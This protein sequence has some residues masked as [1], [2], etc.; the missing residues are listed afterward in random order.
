V[1]NIVTDKL[2]QMMEY[3]IERRGPFMDVKELIEKIRR[4]EIREAL[5]NRI[6]PEVNREDV[7]D[8]E[9]FLIATVNELGR[10]MGVDRC[11]L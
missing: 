3:R 10:M 5:L 8:V 4:Y 1:A 7:I 2:R 11:D 6:N 9:R